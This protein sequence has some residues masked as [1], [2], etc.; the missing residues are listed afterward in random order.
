MI[1]P[2]ISKLSR[3]YS[4]YPL[5]HGEDIPYEDF[6]YMYI[7]LNMT[8][9]EISK[10]LNIS[11]V[12]VSRQAKK[13]NIH[14]DID[15][16]INNT[17]RVMKEK[18]GVEYASKIQ[19]IA[20]KQSHTFHK[21][22]DDIMDKV[23]NK[24]KSTCLLKYGVPMHKQK[25]YKEGVIDIISSKEKLK[26][27][28]ISNNIHSGKELGYKFGMG[29]CTASRYIKKYELQDYIDN[30]VSTPEL[31][32]RK[33]VNNYY[34]TLNNHRDIIPPYEIDIFIPEKNIGIEFNGEYWH[35]F[36]K[37]KKKDAIKLEMCKN[38]GIKLIIIKEQEWKKDKNKLLEWL[39]NEI[40]K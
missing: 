28:I 16:Y 22:N 30:K 20:N 33:A 3:D 13:Y 24:R 10:Y 25:T 40:K 2:D 35:S 4:K 15:N 34:K 39:L 31:E 11:S 6:R 19:S 12:K 29:S 14:K 27:F 37:V 9:N 23:V 17:K 36:D 5:K 8:R 18:Y 26:K 32:I 21:N 1:T 7:E 38:M